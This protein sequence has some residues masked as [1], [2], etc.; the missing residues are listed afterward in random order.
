MVNASRKDWSFKLDK[1]L[2]AYR[3]AYKT[4]IGVSPFKLVYEK[5]CHL[6]VELEHKAYW[7]FKILNFDMKKAGE[8]RVL[9]L[10]ELKNYALVPMTMQ[11]CTK[12][13]PSVGMTSTLSSESFAR[14]MFCCC[15]I[16]AFASF[17]EN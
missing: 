17:P 3:T 13:K 1:A 11:N 6:P 5:S 10:H 8:K 9:D 12:R 16:P 15:S 2:W 4:P 14:K 7:A